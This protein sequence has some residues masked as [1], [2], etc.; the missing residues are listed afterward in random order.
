MP[1]FNYVALDARG[2]ESVGLIEASNTNDAVGQLRQAGYFPT[3]VHEEGKEPAPPK[4][5]KGGAG[6]QDRFEDAPRS[7][8]SKAAR[9]GGQQ[10]GQAEDFDDLHPAVGDA[11]RR[12]PAAAA[13]V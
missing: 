11:H 13:R 12:R 3:S 9:Q 1:K 7:L 4:A 10:E 2:Q 5:K 6:G 8:P